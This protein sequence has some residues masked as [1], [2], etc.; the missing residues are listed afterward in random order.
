MSYLALYRKHR[1]VN[2]AA[3]VGQDHVVR[4]LKNALSKNM[5]SHA[6]LLSGV[7]GTGKTSTAKLLAKALNCLDLVDGEPCNKCMN[8][9]KINEGNFM[10]IIEIDAASNRG[11]DEIRDL[12]EKIKFMPVEGKTKVYIIDEVHMLTGEAFNALLKTLEEPPGHIVFILATTEPHK[13]PLTILSRCQKFDFH[14]IPSDILIERLRFIAAD[15]N[16]RITEE[17]L[18]LIAKLAGGGLRDAISLLDQCLTSYDNEVT[19]EDVSQIAGIV[20]DK[21]IIELF[22]QIADKNVTEIMNLYEELKGGGKSIGQLLFNIVEGLRNILI[23]KSIQKPEQFIIAGEEMIR[24]LKKVGDRF[25]KEEILNWIYK[26]GELESKM[27]YSNHPDILLEVELLK[28][29]TGNP[30]TPTITT[31]QKSTNTKKENTIIETPPMDEDVKPETG[32][33]LDGEKL[34]HRL[35]VIIG[36]KNKSLEAY[37]KGSVGHVFMDN[38][39]TIYFDENKSKFH[40]DRVEL[41]E[42]IELAEVILRKL[43]GRKIK[44]LVEFTNEIEE[45]KEKNS[46]DKITEIFGNNIKYIN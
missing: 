20:E 8:C 33:K 14:K 11:I 30:V 28:G 18:T 24:D 22:Q 38:I 5:V 41:P 45:T 32:V 27:K 31:E 10:D 23:I 40:K 44:I 42:N 19:V 17:A 46:E 43:A 34:W 29:S 35:M 16:G 4:T 1:P 37:Y 13:I 15:C 39:L 12:R 3:L 21:K 6:Y 25:T 7:R 2:F 36:E 9:L 26:L